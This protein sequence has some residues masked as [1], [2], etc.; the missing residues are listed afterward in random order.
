MLLAPNWDLSSLED[1]AFGWE[2][3]GGMGEP[4]KV[5]GRGGG[6]GTDDVDTLF[7]KEEAEVVKLHKVEE[8]ADDE[9]EAAEGIDPSISFLLVVNGS[10]GL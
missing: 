8:A 5:L 4:E 10:T 6:G 2:G 1:D 9:D 7:N 3:E